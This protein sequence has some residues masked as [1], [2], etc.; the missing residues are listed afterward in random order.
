MTGTVVRV[1]V[2][3]NFG[4]IRGEDNREYFFHKS[5]IMHN[6]DFTQELN[7]KKAEFSGLETEKGL[8]AE[9]VYLGES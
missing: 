3:K 6:V 7:G 1:I 2:D 5:A 9:E 8:R 4:F